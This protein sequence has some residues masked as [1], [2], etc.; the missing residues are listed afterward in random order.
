MA[1]TLR[2][3]KQYQKCKIRESLENKNEENKY[4]K[5]KVLNR[6]ENCEKCLSL[7]LNVY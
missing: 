3:D 2:I 6:D 5:I 7:K 1:K 4:T